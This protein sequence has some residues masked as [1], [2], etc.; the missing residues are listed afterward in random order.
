MAANAFINADE[1]VVYCER[2]NIVYDSTEPRTPAQIKALADAHLND[3]DPHAINALQGAGGL[4]I[5]PF[6]QSNLPLPRKSS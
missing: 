4:N 6:P 2:N 3:H 5:P 1:A